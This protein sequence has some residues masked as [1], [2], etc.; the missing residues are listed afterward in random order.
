MLGEQGDVPSLEA[1]RGFM[2][3]ISMPCIFP[4]IS[5]R[6]KPVAC[7]RSVGTVPGSA[8]GGRRSSSLLMSAAE[9]QE[10][11]Y[12][13]QAMPFDQAR[14]VRTFKRYH[15]PLFAR[16]RGVWAGLFLGKAG[17]GAGK[18]AGRER[19]DGHSPREGECGTCGDH[20]GPQWMQM[21]LW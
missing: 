16:F 11:P 21:V 5:K 2:S 8:P 19:L 10:L 13:D 18:A 7:S 15:F 14:A 6:S 1:S 17:H 20:F 3:K 12:L 9:C 4:R